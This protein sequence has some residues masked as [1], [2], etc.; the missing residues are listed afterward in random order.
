MTLVAFLLVGARLEH[1]IDVAAPLGMITL[2][3]PFCRRHARFG[4]VVQLREEVRFVFAHRIE[5]RARFEALARNRQ[6]RLRDIARGRAADRRLEAERRRRAPQRFTVLGGTVPGQRDG[7]KG[8]STPRP[9]AR[10]KAL[11]RLE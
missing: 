5:P 7:W 3:Q 10:I 4:D 9:G 6:R 8:A 1:A 2:E 11:C